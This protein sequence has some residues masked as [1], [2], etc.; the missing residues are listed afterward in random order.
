MERRFT[1]DDF[2]SCIFY[3]PSLLST[4]FSTFIYSRTTSYLSLI[5]LRMNSLL[6]PAVSSRVETEDRNESCHPLKN[7]QQRV[8][9]ERENLMSSIFNQIHQRKTR[10]NLASIK[11]SKK[12]R[13]FT[14]VRQIDKK[15]IHWMPYIMNRCQSKQLH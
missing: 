11:R 10:E 6:P 4:C 1:L 3:Y 15:R 13:P 7:K 2:F 12:G 5:L 9:K 8:R 14:I